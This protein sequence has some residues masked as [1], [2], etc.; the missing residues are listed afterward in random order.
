MGETFTKC[1]KKLNNENTTMVGMKPK[2]AIK[3]DNVPLVKE[4]EYP[5]EDILPSDG[6][7]RFYLQPG[8]EHGDKRRR[9]T[10]FI[11]FKRTFRLDKV[12]EDPNNRVLYYLK[13][14]P[15]RS[16][17]R[18]ELYLIPENTELPPDLVQNW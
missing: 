16:F 15:K 17:V 6:L 7:Y 1:Y 13:D 5:K 18:E 3:L 11:W 9:A 4:E 2:D 12:I 8:E 14:G 10:Y